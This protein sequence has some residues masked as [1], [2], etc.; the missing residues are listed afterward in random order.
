MQDP[1]KAQASVQKALEIDP[2]FASCHRLL[3]VSYTRQQKK[4]EA[5]NAFRKAKE[6]GDPL[7]DKL[8]KDNCK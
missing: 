4:D 5:C 8:I 7:A 3:G 6:L 2:D 1:V